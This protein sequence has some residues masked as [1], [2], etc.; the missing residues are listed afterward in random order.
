LFLF[1]A[2]SLTGAVRADALSQAIGAVN[3]STHPDIPSNTTV[4][5]GK[6]ND[7]GMAETSSD[8]KTITIDKENIEAT[9]PGLSDSPDSLPGVLYG[10]LAHETYHA[11]EAQGHTEPAPSPSGPPPYNTADRACGDVKLSPGIAADMCG[12][13]NAIRQANPGAQCNLCKLYDHVRKC[14]NEGCAVPGGASEK[15]KD[16]PGQAYPGDIPQCDGCGP[17]H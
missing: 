10:L 2:C 4:C 6:V 3:M 12:L 9:L 5:Y 13:I 11:N 14:Y 16:C 8:G 1:A 7:G 15:N 17:C